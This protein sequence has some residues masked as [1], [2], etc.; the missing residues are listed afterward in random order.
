MSDGRISLQ[1]FLGRVC[2][3]RGTICVGR[4]SSP[5][6]HVFVGFADIGGVCAASLRS[7]V[8]RANRSEFPEVSPERYCYLLRCQETNHVH[9]AFADFVFGSIVLHF[10]VVTFMG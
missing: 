7:Q 6:W 4:Y 2:C 5:S 8:D 1:F 10:F 9:R 3:G